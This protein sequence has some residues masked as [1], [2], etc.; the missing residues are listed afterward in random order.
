MCE[1]WAKQHVSIVISIVHIFILYYTLLLYFSLPLKKWHFEEFSC[2][3]YNITLNTYRC[4]Y[5][6]GCRS[7]ELHLRILDNQKST[8]FG[9]TVSSYMVNKQ[10][11]LVFIQAN[12]SVL[13][14]QICQCQRLKSQIQGDKC[15][16]SPPMAILNQ[17]SEAEEAGG[18]EGLFKFKCVS[19]PS[20]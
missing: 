16:C 8:T 12:H 18:C 14:L 5:I 13:L 20:T 9:T 6:L 7:L 2:C 11:F 3:L 15:G 10:I 1:L 4:L 19:S 17:L